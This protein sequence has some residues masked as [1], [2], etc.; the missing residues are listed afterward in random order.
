M[1]K[2]MLV[3]GASRGIGAATARLA[4]QRGYALGINYRERREEA[5]ALVNAIRAGG[6]EALAIQADVGV[7]EQVEQMF[8]RL[9]EAFGRLDVL[10]N[11]AGML[12][13]QMRLEDMDAARFERVLRANVIGSF[14]CAKQAIRRLSTRHGGTG[15]AIVNLSSVAARIGAPDEYID[16]AAAKGAIDSMTL[17]MAKELAG[18]GI[19][20]NAVRPGVI[21]T[22]IHASG[23]EPDRIERVRHSVPMKRGGEAEE[24]AAAILWLASDEAS[25]T[26]GA[27]LD[28]SGGR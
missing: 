1:R 10:V 7:E 5:E 3:T 13:Q 14:L 16:Y 19:R 22:D 11:N 17:G 12:E 9:D 23:G 27:I 6:G 4:A 24:I 20:V 8:Q 18:E 15:G 21:H 25:Y 28:V 2:V 26:T